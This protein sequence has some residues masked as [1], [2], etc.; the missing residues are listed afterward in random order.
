VT[1]VSFK[2]EEGDSR[3]LKLRIGFASGRK[4]KD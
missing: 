2:A 3:E 4:F 1:D